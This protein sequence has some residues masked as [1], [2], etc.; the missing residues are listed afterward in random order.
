MARETTVY[1]ITTQILAMGAG[2]SLSLYVFAAP[3]EIWSRLKYVS[4]GSMELMGANAGTPGATGRADASGT[5][6]LFGAA[7]VIEFSGAARYFLQ[8]TGATAVA[9]LIRGLSQGF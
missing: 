4:G 5:G 7:E 3:G 1:G 2:A 8:A 6:Y 9:H